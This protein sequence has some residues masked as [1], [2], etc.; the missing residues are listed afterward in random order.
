MYIRFVQYIKNEL[1]CKG[2]DLMLVASNAL[3]ASSCDSNWMK[4]KFLL[5]LI[6]KIF[7]YGSKCLSKSLIL[8]LI[9]SKFMTNKVFV[10]LTLAGDLL[11]LPDRLP[12]R[13][14][15]K[16]NFEISNEKYK[17]QTFQSFTYS[18]ASKTN[19]YLCPLN[20]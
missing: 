7:P 18:L 9:G 13:S 4:A 16:Y 8:V 6:F 10:G 12:P 14:C 19:S 17:S 3:V 20:T 11:E 1:A 5:I 15:W 2:S